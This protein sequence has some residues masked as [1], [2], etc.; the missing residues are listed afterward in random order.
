MNSPNYFFC[1]SSNA[2]A[3][4][5]TQSVERAVRQ[6]NAVDLMESAMSV[7]VIGNRREAVI[8]ACVRRP[9]PYDKPLSD[10]TGKITV[11]SSALGL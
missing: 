3:G 11:R 5:E 4:T 1:W 7:L 8:H 9:S 6:A 10:K 2:C